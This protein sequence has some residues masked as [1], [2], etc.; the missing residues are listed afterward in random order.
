MGGKGCYTP[1]AVHQQVC[2]SVECGNHDRRSLGSRWRHRLS[3]LEESRAVRRVD[4][5]HQDPAPPQAGSG[6]LAG[7]SCPGSDEGL[8]GALER[9]LREPRCTEIERYFSGL[10]FLLAKEFKNLYLIVTH[11]QKFHTNSGSVEKVSACA[12]DAVFVKATIEN[13]FL[14]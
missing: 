10:F 14:L 8:L 12:Y 2:R 5:H 1:W 3:S 9:W 13:V 6:R 11:K 7:G 4:P